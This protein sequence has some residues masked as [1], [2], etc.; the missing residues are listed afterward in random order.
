MLMPLTF[1][2]LD[3]QA[4]QGSSL[5]TVLLAAGVPRALSSS[6]PSNTHKSWSLGMKGTMPGVEEVSLDSLHASLHTPAL[7]MSSVMGMDSSRMVRK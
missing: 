6:S 3:K 1:S 7:M 5:L 4:A 2:T